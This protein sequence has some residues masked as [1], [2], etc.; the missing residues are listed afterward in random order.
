[1]LLKPHGFCVHLL[2]IKR[3]R[4]DRYPVHKFIIKKKRC[5]EYG[6]CVVVTEKDVMLN[7]TMRVIII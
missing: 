1:M 3:T 4:M 2:S 7:K 5:Q 6:F